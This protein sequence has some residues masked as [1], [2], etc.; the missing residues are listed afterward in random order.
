MVGFC[1][2]LAR[3]SREWGRGRVCIDEEVLVEVLRN[4][5][6]GPMQRRRLGGKPLRSE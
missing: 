1:G 5:G 3:V 4:A 6:I 2:A